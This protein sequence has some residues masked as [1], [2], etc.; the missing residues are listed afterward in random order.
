MNNGPRYRGCDKAHLGFIVVLTPPWFYNPKK[1]IPTYNFE[2]SN[3]NHVM[4]NSVFNR[5]KGAIDV[6]VLV[7]HKKVTLVARVHISSFQ[8]SHRSDISR[9]QLVERNF[10]MNSKPKCVLYQWK[11]H[12]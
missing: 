9:H 12:V 8:S 10:V 11:R 6:S 4:E 2:P 5:S 7:L 3:P 1:P